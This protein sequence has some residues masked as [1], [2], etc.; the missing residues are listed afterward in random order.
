MFRV[1]WIV[2]WLKEQFSRVC[3]FGH[4][5][6]KAL[7]HAHHGTHLSYFFMV[8]MHGP[9]HYAAL[10]LFVLV[11]ALWVMDVEID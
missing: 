6:K 5:H 1:M 10:A 11:L 8:G 2:V 9:Y 7:K 3:I 4:C